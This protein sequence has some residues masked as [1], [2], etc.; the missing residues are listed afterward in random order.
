M[1]LNMGVYSE[2]TSLMLFEKVCHQRDS[3]LNL[4]DIYQGRNSKYICIAETC[5]IIFSANTCIYSHLVKCF[6]LFTALMAFFPTFGCNFI[7][8]QDISKSLLHSVWSVQMQYQSNEIKFITLFMNVKCQLNCTFFLFHPLQ[9]CQ[10]MFR[11]FIMTPISC[12]WFMC[13]NLNEVND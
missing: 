13:V 8:I 6:E 1:F 12:L 7:F 11:K 4:F 2:S 3:C 5:S 9:M 10:F